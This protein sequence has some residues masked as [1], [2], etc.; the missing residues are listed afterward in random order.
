MGCGGIDW[1][2][3][4]KTKEK[5]KAPRERGR[6]SIHGAVRYRSFEIGEPRLI[7][8]SAERPIANRA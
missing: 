4:R 3:I 6:R 7:E 8:W 5:I 2:R 1:Q